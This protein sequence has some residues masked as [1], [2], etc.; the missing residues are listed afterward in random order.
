[1]SEAGLGSPFL[2]TYLD[3][4][5]PGQKMNDQGDYGKNQQQMNQKSSHVVHHKAADP[6]EEK[7]QSDGEPNETA[8]ESS[9]ELC[10][11]DAAV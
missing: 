2:F 7:Q 10:R 9:G 4:A 6:R 3:G 5:P 8:H 11:L 1:L